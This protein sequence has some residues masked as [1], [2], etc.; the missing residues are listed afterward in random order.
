MSHSARAT[1]QVEFSISK[2]T[3]AAQQTARLVHQLALASVTAEVPSSAGAGAGLG[4]ESVE[5]EMT[6]VSQG[7]RAIAGG[8]GEV[9]LNAGV[10]ENDFHGAGGRRRH[11][12]G[13]Y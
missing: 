1:L 9:E 10:V 13:G 3:K 5:E 7:S 11:L 2:H 12:L 4:T 8:G 6:H